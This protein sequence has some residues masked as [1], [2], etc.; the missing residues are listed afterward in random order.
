ML[1]DRHSYSN[2]VTFAA[3][4]QDYGFGMIIGEETADL[5]TTYG[6]MES[7]TLPN[8]GVSVGF[9]K[10]HIIRPNGDESVRGVLPDI[11][12][13]SPVIFGEGDVVL[14]AT[15]AIVEGR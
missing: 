10:A 2:A 13:P 8:S 15:L 14:A 4:V 3:M 6:A 12:I 7:F 11:T 1:V 9:P 5:A